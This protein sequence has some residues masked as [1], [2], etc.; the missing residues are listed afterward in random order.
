MD[1]DEF[2]LHTLDGGGNKELSKLTVNTRDEL[3]K[4]IANPLFP[5]IVKPG[6]AVAQTY[7][8]GAG[9]V[10]PRMFD[11]EK[12]CGKDSYCSKVG[13]ADEAGTRPD[14][15]SVVT[16]TVTV[17]LALRAAAVTVIKPW[18]VP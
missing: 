7:G 12:I 2:F 6:T 1:P 13:G 18:P 14:W 17:T 8:L 5:D 15:S 4:L 10:S 3:V 11:R 9:W 16:V